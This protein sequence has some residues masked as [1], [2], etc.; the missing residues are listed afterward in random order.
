M[1]NIVVTVPPY[2]DFK[3]RLALRDAVKLAGM[4]P[5]SFMHENTA[6]ALYHGINR[7]DN[8]TMHRVLFYNMGSSALKVSLVE[9]EAIDNQGKEKSQYPQI[10]TI[11]VIDEAWD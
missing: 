1:H 11:R 3:Y 10:E 8:E 5:L 6:A 7:L 2:A 4:N 9:F